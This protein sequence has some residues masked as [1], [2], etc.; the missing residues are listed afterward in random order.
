MICQSTHFI[1]SSLSVYCDAVCYT[2][3][4]YCEI[5]FKHVQF[6]DKSM[7]NFDIIDNDNIGIKEV[8]RIPNCKYV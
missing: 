1:R 8:F 2:T 6:I 3:Y 5:K 4:I 7:N